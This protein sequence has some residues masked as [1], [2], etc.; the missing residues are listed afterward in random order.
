MLALWVLAMSL[1]AGAAPAAPPTAEAIMARVAANQDRSNQLRA[2][3]IYHQRMHVASIK[4]NGKLMCEETRDYLVIPGP[5]ST[6]KKLQELDG[7][8]WHKGQYVNFSRKLGDDDEGIDCN[9]VDSLDDDLTNEHSKDGFGK[10]LFPLTS[11]QQK[12][13]RFAL[14]GEETLEG[15]RVYRVSFRPKDKK[16]VD[17]AGE[18]DIDVQ[19]FQPVDVF[20]KLSRRLPLAIRTFLVAL[21]DIGFNVQYQRQPDGVWFPASFGTEFRIKVLMFY[22]RVYTISLTNTGFERTHV[23]SRIELAGPAAAPSENPEPKTETPKLKT[24]N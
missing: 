2:D 4:T 21:P 12:K 11:E 1:T 3:Y 20:T 19:D 9:V 8:Y 10:D 16:D 23:T 6:S 24:E 13:D 5:K 22:R 17:W 7:R 18:A 14:I 15:R